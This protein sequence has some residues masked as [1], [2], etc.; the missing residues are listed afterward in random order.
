MARLVM[1]AER[2]PPDLGGVATSAQRLAKSLSQLG[3]Q[4][5]VVAFST[6]L[7]AGAADTQNL[8]GFGFVHRLG[9]ARH[10]DFTLQQA[11]NFLEW[12]HSEVNFE[13]V[14]SHYAHHAG[15]LGLWFA[16]LY[17][18]PSILSVRGNDLDR[19]VFPTGDFARLQWMLQRATQVVAVSQ[20]LARKIQVLVP[21]N[22]SVLPNSVDPDVF[23]R[24][25]R[26]PELVSRYDLRPGELILGFTGE[27]RAKKGM[28]FLLQGLH[29]LLQ[30]R[31]VRLLLVGEV[32]GQDTGE[33]ERTCAEMDGIDSAII[34]TG[35]LTDPRDVAAHLKLMDVFLQPSLWDGM[36]NSVLEAM[37]ARVPIVASDAGAIPELIEH[38]RT[39]YLVSK[40]HLHQLADHVERYLSWPGA[41]RSQMIE[42]AYQRA[43]SEHSP[44]LE[45]SRLS[46]ILPQ[47]EGSSSLA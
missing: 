41:T 26:S 45:R 23:S 38:G 12:L 15:F 14:W 46:E 33:F 47:L 4:V 6:R 29:Q 43:V 22:V 2:F 27:L 31:P 24:A 35:Q 30:R 44:E 36:P 11:Q 21:R 37:V 1:L 7:P 3:H 17:H 13:L 8:P 42:A 10:A 28:S 18:L 5:H 32:R 20:D 16:E 39:G 25:E 9:I 34:R 19:Q 40:A